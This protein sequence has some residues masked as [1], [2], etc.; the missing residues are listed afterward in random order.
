M[1]CVCAHTWDVIEPLCTAITMMA[2]VPLLSQ[3]ESVWETDSKPWPH[4]ALALSSKATQVTSRQEVEPENQIVL[5]RARQEDRLIQ[6][7]RTS[8]IPSSIVSNVH[9]FN[10]SPFIRGFQDNMSNWMNSLIQHQD[11][12][13]QMV[14]QRAHQSRQIHEQLAHT[15][16]Q[17]ATMPSQHDQVSY[18]GAQ[19]AHREAQLEQVRAERDNHFIQE[20]EVLAH[21]RLLSSEA[22]D[23]KSRVVTEAEQV[24]CRESAQATQQATEIQEAMDKQ[25]QARWRQAEAELRDLCSS[26]SAQAQALASKLQ[27]TQLERQQLYSAQE[28][29]LQLEAQALRQSQQEEHQASSIP[30]HSPRTWIG[31]TRVPSTSRRTTW[32]PQVTVENAAISASIIQSRD[33]WALHRDVE[34]AWEV[35]NAGSD[36]SSL[37]QTRVA[38]SNR[39]AWARECPQHSFS[40]QMSFMDSTIWDDDNTRS[41][42]HKWTAD[43]ARRPVQLGPSPVTQQYSRRSLYLQRNGVIKTVET[44][45]KKNVNCLE[46]PRKLKEIQ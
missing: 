11:G 43:S 38:K 4:C 1:P 25:Y 40:R 33:P 27:E 24:L 2:Q 29:Q 10:M 23:W 18:L 30:C 31:N 37:V 28:R 41:T 35:R 32:D 5:K 6:H 13:L 3:R 8:S 39:R 9:A 22:K 34:H 42:Y 17:R 45:V 14:A 44:K 16:A 21:V 36:V 20:E 15:V 26:N 7:S 12:C 46:I 19:L